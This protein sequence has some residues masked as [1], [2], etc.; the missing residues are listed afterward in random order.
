MDWI[1][2]PLTDIAKIATGMLVFL[3]AVAYA[4]LVGLRSFAKM[5]NL[6]FASTIAIG[7]TMG[8]VILSPPA[9]VAFRRDERRPSSHDRPQHASA[10]IA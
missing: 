1:T 10:G 7:S 8:S 9:R 2:A 4:H 5:S 6:D 3:V